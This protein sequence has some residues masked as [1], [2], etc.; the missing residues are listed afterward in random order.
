MI[1]FLSLKDITTKYS[2]EIHAAVSRVVDSGWYLQGSENELFEKEYSAWIG[3]KYTVGCGNGLDA[4]IWILR[5]YKEMGVM[6]DGDEVIVPANTFIATVLAITENNLTPVFVEPCYDTLEIDDRLLESHLT[7]RTRAVMIVHLY[8]RCAY[9]DRIGNFCR[10]HGLKLLEDN[11]QAHGCVWKGVKTGALGDA[12]AH[13]FYPGKNI[14]A[15]GDAG[16]VTTNDRELADCVRSLGNYGSAKKYVFRYVGRN[17]RLDEIQAAVLRVKLAHLDEDVSYRRNVAE[18][19]YEGISNP[20][21]TLPLHLPRE[22]NAYH[23]FP[24]LSADRD[25][26]QAFLKERGIQ[27]LIHYPIPPHKQECYARWNGMSLPITE[28]IH[29]EELSL[30]IGPTIK[31][32]EV[33]SVIAAVNAF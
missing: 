24:I 6:R 7:D 26:L 14:G 1:P 20:R 16:A 33:E 19:Y 12:A 13:S 3:C 25:S 29:A 32:E 15:L 9:T 21:V 27:T 4:L 23:L 28:R 31:E 11:A 22:N 8:G 18:M 10:T 30:P 17:S 5:A 2:D